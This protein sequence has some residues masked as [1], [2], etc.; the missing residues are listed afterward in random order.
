M[1]QW[2][3]ISSDCINSDN[4]THSFIYQWVNIT[5]CPKSNA[6]LEEELNMAP[7]INEI[8]FMIQFIACIIIF[9]AKFYNV[10]NG[11]QIWD[12]K[13]EKRNLW[14]CLLLFAVSLLLSAWGFS[15]W[16]ID[17][18]NKT[19]EVSLMFQG[20]IGIIILILTIVECVLFAEA[21]TK[22]L[23]TRMGTGRE[24]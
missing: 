14:I 20:V 19:L 3:D 8:L 15:M 22:K 1:R 6:E 10:L 13:D 2:E 4:S 5:Q 9:I 24:S 12:K 23:S 7:K 16:L 11:G 21:F 17:I 18:L